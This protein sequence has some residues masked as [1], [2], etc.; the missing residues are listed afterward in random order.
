M[1]ENIGENLPDIG[2][3]NDLFGFDTENTGNRSKNKQL[4]LHEMKMFL[5]SKRINQDEKATYGMGEN[6]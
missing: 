3:G 4:G 2:L 1:E 5:H 6:I